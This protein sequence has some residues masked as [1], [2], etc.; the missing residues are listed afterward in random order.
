VTVKLERRNFLPEADFTIEFDGRPP[1]AVDVQVAQPVRTA[2]PQGPGY[3]SLGFELPARIGSAPGGKAPT[4]VLVFDKSYHQSPATLRLQ[5]QIVEGILKQAASGEV[6][7]LLACVRKARSQPEIGR[8]GWGRG[9]CDSLSAGLIMTLNRSVLCF[10]RVTLTAC[11]PFWLSAAVGC[12]NDGGGGDGGTSGSA[13]G[14]TSSGARGSGTSGATTAGGAGKGGDGSSMGGSSGQ[15]GK[16]GSAGSAGA[17]GGAAGSGSGGFGGGKGGGGNVEPGE[18]CTANCPTGTIQTC[19]ENCPF[20]P[21]DDDGFFAD[22]ACSTY[23]ASPINSETI[24]CAKGQT[25][26][27]C[28]TTLDKLQEFYT[29]S[30]TA[31]TPTVTKCDGGCGVG[32]DLV[33]K[34]NE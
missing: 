30:C 16:S 12:G 18:P 9:A 29:V 21:C 22:E 28:L 19:I 1:P 26:A 4:R 5:A 15:G 7:R 34:C 2:T 23:Y 27:Y 14:S 24:F 25:D 31:G 17:S 20:G 3:V 32:P 11:L 10:A 6:F 33:G 13:S 8:S